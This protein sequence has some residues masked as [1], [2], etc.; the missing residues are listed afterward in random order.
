MELYYFK[1][2]PPNFGDE[3]NAWLWPR[4]APAIDGVDDGR[5]VLG[6][7]LIL[8]DKFPFD[9]AKKKIVLGAGYGG[10]TPPPVLNDGTWD[11]RFVRGPQTAEVLGLE[12]SKAITDAAV[13]VRTQAIAASLQ[14]YE[15][16][17]MPHWESIEQGSWQAACTREGINFIDPRE[18][19]EVIVSNIKASG[20]LLTEAMHGAIVA[21]A[22]GTPWVAF[23]PLMSVHR[24]KWTDWTRSLGLAY[25]PVRLLLPTL[26]EAFL[27][28]LN[29]KKRSC[30]TIFCAWSAA[31]RERA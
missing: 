10:Y 14:N 27:H 1:G 30:R 17:F 21:D 8:Y 7:G 13:L 9:P 31:P 23:S 6:I 5:I 11:V 25:R 15:V 18:A 26:Q 29:A 4:I 20:L 24:F 22:L 28:L 12:P 16:S 19:V 3:L 2:P